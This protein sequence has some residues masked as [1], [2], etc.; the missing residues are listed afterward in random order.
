MEAGLVISRIGEHARLRA[1]VFVS[2]DWEVFGRY[3]WANEDTPAD[4]LSVLTI[5]CNRYFAGQA[6]KWTT[7]FGYAFNAISPMFGSGTGGGGLGPG[8]VFTGWRTDTPG[9]DGQ[10]M[11]RSQLQFVF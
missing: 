8:G 9:E 7:D 5:G 1:G 6:I 11:I 2:D 4:D 10:F 3:E